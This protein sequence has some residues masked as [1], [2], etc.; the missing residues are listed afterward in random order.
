MSVYRPPTCSATP[1]W[2]GA[3]V[4]FLQIGVQSRT[5]E[6]R[7]MRQVIPMP[8]NVGKEGKQP[9]ASGL[10]EGGSVASD[11][12]RRVIEVVLGIQSQHRYLRH[13]CR[14]A[15][16][17]SVRIGHAPLPPLAPDEIEH[18]SHRLW[19]PAGISHGSHAPPR[20][21]ANQL[22]RAQERSTVGRTM[23]RSGK[24]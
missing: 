10:F 20:G 17:A 24:L 23:Q 19:M 9:L 11:R 8:A 6:Q 5:P 16:E 1:I 22:R 13:A 3:A 4:Q 7:L 12:A 21:P 15:E 2:H 18:P 14:I